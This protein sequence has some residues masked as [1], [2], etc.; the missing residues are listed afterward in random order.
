MDSFHPFNFFLAI[1]EN[2]RRTRGCQVLP[3]K[4]FRPTW[5]RIEMG[6][7]GWYIESAEKSYYEKKEKSKGV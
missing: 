4:P 5:F 6:D 3:E 1:E 7:L 2:S